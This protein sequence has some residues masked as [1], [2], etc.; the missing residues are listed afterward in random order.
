MADGTREAPK[1]RGG[2]AAR[3]LCLLTGLFLFA[4]GIVM[5]LESGLGLSPWDVLSQGVA[6][7]TP[8]SF[9]MANVVIGVAVLAIAWRLGARVGP[10]TVANAVLIGVFVDSLLRAQAI[11]DLSGAGIVG[12]AA[13]LG[14]GI[15]LIGLATALYIGAGM[16]AGARDSL[17]LVLAERMG[18]RVRVVRTALEATATVLGFVLGGTVGIGTLA[19]ALAIGPAVEA[20]FSLLSRSPLALLGEQDNGPEARAGRSGAPNHTQLTPPPCGDPL[21]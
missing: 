19:F 21:L 14:G 12:Q 17:M 9:G 18:A 8:L 5:L 10:G 20:A 11:R 2:I 15:A 3:S 7:H 4:L 16:G 1:T 6:E 13:L